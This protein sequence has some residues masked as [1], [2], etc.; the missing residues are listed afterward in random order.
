L[1]G[2][3]AQAFAG[4][5][6]VPIMGKR[7]NFQECSL[8]RSH[9]R[10]PC[11]T[12]NLGA[13]FDCIG[14]ALDRYLEAW[15]EPAEHDLELIREG[16][17]AGLAV[18]PAGDVLVQAFAFPLTLRDLQPR[19]TIRVRSE[20][21]VGRGLGSSAAAR[22]AGYVLA[23]AALGDEPPAEREWA[24]A[25]NF[26]AFRYAA[27][28]EGHPDNAAP[29]AFGGLVAGMAPVEP[30]PTREALLNP[31]KFQDAGRYP[32]RLVTMKLPL[33]ADIGWAYAAPAAGISTEA[34]R[35]ALPPTVSRAE[36][37][38]AI[39]RMPALLRG[40]ET[41]DPAL[42]SFGFDDRFHVPHRLPLIPGGAAAMAAGCEAGAWAITISGSG[43][44]LIAAC[45]HGNEAAVAAA[46]A[47]AFRRAPVPDPDG[48]VVG[49]ALSPDLEGAQILP[50]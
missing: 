13:G 16:T 2:P 36:A 42:L 28:A 40:L 10:V 46:M 27:G 50:A 25:R 22:V 3:T 18:E 7:V 23:E 8:V 17:L 5:A 26:S 6:V 24:R 20:I 35:R 29:C 34:A 44:G 9:V 47:D 45:P 32:L 12:S 11:S 31:P 30:M 33:S 15:Y 38:D 4:E 1:F 48:E 39:R 49:F 37:V 19:G 41:A 43:S 14:L 21:P